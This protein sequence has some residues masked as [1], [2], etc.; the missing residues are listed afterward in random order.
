MWQTIQFFSKALRAIKDLSKKRR[1]KTG[2]TK[3][4][5]IAVIN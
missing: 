3:G 5:L 2:G 4:K 1:E